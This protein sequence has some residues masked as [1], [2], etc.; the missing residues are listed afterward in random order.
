MKVLDCETIDSTYE[1]LEQIL[2]T[3]RSQLETVFD[4]VDVERF[5]RDNPRHP[6]PPEDL[7]FSE[8]RKVATL[9][10]NYDRTCWFHLTR[11]APTNTFDQGILPL[12]QCLDAIWNFLYSL[13]KRQV[14]QEEWNRF[15]HDMGSDHH[16]DLYEMKAHDPMHW[17]PYALLTRDHAFKAG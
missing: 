6:Q 5:Y 14:T 3:G 10:G 17:G 11:T 16:A 4:G 2:G 7:I 8:V 15:R 9:S 12:G 1:S 13:A